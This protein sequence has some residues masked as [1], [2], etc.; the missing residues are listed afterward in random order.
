MFFGKICISPRQFDHSAFS[1]FPQKANDGSF[2]REGEWKLDFD[3][4]HTK[5]TTSLKYRP[6]RAETPNF[7]KIWNSQIQKTLPL[8]SPN[9]FF[10]WFRKRDNFQKNK[11]CYGAPSVTEIKKSKERKRSNFLLCSLPKNAP[12]EADKGYPP[13]GPSCGPAG[14]IKGARY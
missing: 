7:K 4:K 8:P 11:I 10:G 6:C 2:S 3:E 5:N 14:V 12:H 9:S 1:D 13:T